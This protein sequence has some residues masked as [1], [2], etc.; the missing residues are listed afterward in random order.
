MAQVSSLSNSEELLQLCASLYD[1]DSMILQ[2][3]INKYLQHQTQAES[4]CLLLILEDDEEI[5]CDVVGDTVLEETIRFPISNNG[6]SLPLQMNTST[7]DELFPHKNEL[8]TKLKR[9]F[10]SFL[11]IPI[12]HP[13]RTENVTLLTCLMNK[14]N[15]SRFL[16]DDRRIVTNCFQYTVN[17]LLS[18][19]AFEKERRL[20]CQCQSLLTVAKNLFT[21]LDNVTV[22]LRE[23]MDEARNLTKA[24]KCSLFLVDQQQQE[25]VAKVFDG[26][27]TDEELSGF[28]V[29]LPISQGIAGHVAMTGEL[30]NIRDAYSHPLFYKEIDKSTGFTTRNILCFPI[31]DNT[32]VIGIAELCNKI[33]DLYF[34]T[35]DEEIAMAF[36]IYCGI[37]IMHSLMWKKVRDAQHRSK[38]SNELMMYHMKVSTDEVDRLIEVEVPSLLSIHSNFCSFSFTPR[39]LNDH[40][41]PTVNIIIGMIEDMGLISKWQISKQTLARFLLMVKKGYRDTPYHNWLHAFSAAHFCYVSIKKLRLI[42]EGY[43]TALECLSL[44][45]A[46]L[47][48]DLDHRGTTNSFQVSSKSLLAALYSSEGSVMER[49]HFAQTM[50]ILNTE[51]CNVFEKLPEKDYRKALDM[52]RDVILATDLAQHLRSLVAYEEMIANGF[53]KTNREHHSLLQCLLMTSCDLSDQT[54][55]WA[56]SKKIAEMIYREFFKQGDLERAMGLLPSEMMDREKACIPQL[57]VSF[58]SEIVVPVYKLLS[59]LFP[60]AGETLAT[61]ETNCCYWDRLQDL[62]KT[63]SSIHSSSLD[64]FDDDELDSQVMS[65][66]VGAAAAAANAND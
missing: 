25:L 64:I 6:V 4:V 32:G 26:N 35:F 56:H 45:V 8:A 17:I 33:D 20:K 50:C 40:E 30:L 49:H 43:L 19:V 58:L 57:Q 3:K 18:T 52:V 23:I 13:A 59:K 46:C 55:T 34:S 47:C 1:Q 63:R 62:Y 51:G 54:K 16:D 61:A 2:R 38:L 5:T 10:N 27:A 44:F 14:K 28:D 53:D 9:T 11:C 29:R 12:P 36:S 15:S 41:T 37:S 31:K 21:H 60:D 7:V 48:H 24:E 42:E 39:D 66:V 65:T 22:L